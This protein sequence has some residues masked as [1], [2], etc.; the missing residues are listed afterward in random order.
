MGILRHTEEEQLHAAQEPFAILA[1]G[2]D[3]Q[4]LGQDQLRLVERDVLNL[5]GGMTVWEQVARELSH[6]YDQVLQEP[7]KAAPKPA[8]SSGPPSKPES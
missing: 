1:F 7:G 4:K 5:L 6:E 8:P 3:P 2:G